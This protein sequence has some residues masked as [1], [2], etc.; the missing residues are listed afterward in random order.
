MCLA[1]VVIIRVIISTVVEVILHAGILQIDGSQ[2]DEAIRRFIVDPQRV[3]RL[4]GGILVITFRSGL[5]GCR[6]GGYNRNSVAGDRSDAR[7][8]RSVGDR[9]D[10]AGYRLRESIAA[11]ELI[12]FAD[13]PCY[14]CLCKAESLLGERLGR[15]VDGDRAGAGGR[16]VLSPAVTVI[17]IIGC[18]GNSGHLASGTVV[19]PNIIVGAARSIPD[20]GLTAGT[21]TTLNILTII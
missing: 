8:G 2:R 3:G 6:T 10:V 1:G 20:R 4:G 21:G 14:R 15:A 13:N 16:T 7:V 17:Q 18:A 5:D 11:V 19:S 9:S 12:T